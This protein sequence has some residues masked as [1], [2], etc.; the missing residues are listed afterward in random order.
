MPTYVS[1]Q[2]LEELKK[3][4][5]KRK[6]NRKD[7]AEK[8]SSAK[9]LGDISENFEYHEAKEQQAINETRIIQLDEMVKDFVIIEETTGSQRIELGASFDVQVGKEKRPFQIVGSTEADPTSGK[10]SNESPI[11]QAFLG[12]KAGETVEVKV[13]SGKV[14]YKILSIR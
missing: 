7:I 2:G 12:R 11:G 8:I 4:L 3:E 6:A 5:A 14:S 10:I 13:P 1:S 9:E